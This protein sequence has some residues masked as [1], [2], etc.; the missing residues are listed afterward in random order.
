MP[1]GGA[2]ILGPTGIP[3][4]VVGTALARRAIGALVGTAND[5]PDVEEMGHIEISWDEAALCGLLAHRDHL[6]AQVTEVQAK[7]TALETEMRRRLAY[8]AGMRAF[9]VDQDPRSS[10]P[11]YVDGVPVDD[12]AANL[13]DSG[14]VS[15]REDVRNHIR[16]ASAPR[17]KPE[18]MP[19]PG[20]GRNEGP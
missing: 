20:N 6:H 8:A 5:H 17:T 13:W 4:P 15:A 11:H 1:R 16:M 9:L 10:N 7:N 3:F 14:W 2:V 19:L 12:V 18:P